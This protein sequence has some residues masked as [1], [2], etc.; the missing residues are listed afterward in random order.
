MASMLLGLMRSGLFNGLDDSFLTELESRVESVVVGPGETVVREGDLADAFFVVLSGDLEVTTTADNGEVIRLGSFESGGCFGEQALLPTSSGRRSAN[1]LGAAPRSELARLSSD[2]L[3]EMME[4]DPGLT[5][6]FAALGQE[7]EDNQLARRSALVRGLLGSDGIEPRELTLENGTPLYRQGDSTDGFFVILGGRVELLQEGEGLPIRLAKLGPG[8]CVGERDDDVRGTT[9][10]A[11]GTTRLLAFPTAALDG[12][13][14][15]ELDA[16]LTTLQQSW[17]LPQHGFVTQHLGTDD[18]KPCLTQI[19][20]LRGGR[21]LVATHLIGGETVRLT[22][23]GSVPVRRLETEASDLVAQVDAD[24]RLSSITARARGPVLEWLFGRA[25]EDLPLKPTEEQSFLDTGSFRP[26][27]DGFLCTCL[28]VRRSAVRRA[29]DEGVTE[30]SVLQ[31]RTG[32]GLSCGSCVPTLLEALGSG[33]FEATNIVSIEA[34]TDRTRRVTLDCDADALPGQHV[35]LRVTHEGKSIDRPYTLSGAAGGP[36]EVTVQ[37]EPGG[38]FGD[39]LFE[40]ATPGTSLEASRPQ[41]SFVWKPG[42][43]PVLFFAAGIGLTPALSFART[44]V[45]RGWPHWLI[46][47]WSTPR[48]EDVALLGELRQIAMPNLDLRVRC[49]ANAG[50]LT[51]ADVQALVDRFPDAETFVC[52]PRPFQDDVKT[53]ILAAGVP[54]VRVH[55]EDFDPGSSAGPRG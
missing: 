8:L 55:S 33:G 23:P 15:P 14:S 30:L 6:H 9:A 40:Q 54:S 48:P 16:H 25:I 22:V 34:P 2:L 49:T 32:A 19:Y 17:E 52:G 42:P 41:G 43:A 1:V 46:V 47:D 4:G 10:L 39:W 11:D 5:A 21:T 3:A 45:D 31:Q 35:V 20:S 7:Y 12:V 37:R 24:G 18:G 53:W 13:L 50:R 44:L 28:R 29:V 26:V 38:A 36:L 27:D 51:P